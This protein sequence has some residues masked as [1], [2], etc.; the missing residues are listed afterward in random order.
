M[1]GKLAIKTFSAI[2]AIKDRLVS[3]ED[4]ASSVEWVLLV[5]G[6]AAVVFGITGFVSGW[7]AT[8]SPTIFKTPTPA[9]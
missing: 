5:I 7:W 1:F 8:T 6:I 3:N 4:G 9:S 2:K